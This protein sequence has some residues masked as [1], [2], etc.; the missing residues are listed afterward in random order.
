MRP[1][2]KITL[3]YQRRRRCV[4]LLREPHSAEHAVPLESCRFATTPPYASASIFCPV[5]CMQN[6]C[7]TVKHSHQPCRPFAFEICTCLKIATE[8]F[9]KSV[10]R[11][12]KQN[13]LQVFTDHLRSE[14]SACV[15]VCR[16]CLRKHPLMSTR[17]CDLREVELALGLHCGKRRFSSPHASRPGE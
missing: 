1:P 6:A 14:A 2:A 16:N 10:N 5:H 12:S 17:K 15:V 4:L 7:K 11:S 3:A 9:L 8:R 13:A